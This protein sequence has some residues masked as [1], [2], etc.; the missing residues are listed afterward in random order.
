M[1]YRLFRWFLLVFGALVAL[2]I[3]GCIVVVVQMKGRQVDAYLTM[4]YYNSLTKA[5]TAWVSGTDTPVGA[6]PLPDGGYVIGVKYVDALYQRIE[7]RIIWVDG[8]GRETESTSA[9]YPS[10]WY[11]NPYYTRGNIN[12]GVDNFDYKLEYD[13]RL[14]G[15]ITNMQLNK[16]YE[17]ALYWLAKLGI[18]VS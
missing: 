8:H 14:H 4:A 13:L 3:V 16:V 7:Y 1:R 12:N 2:I 10:G 6:T 9:Q 17:S 5:Q 18:K 11:Y 15:Q